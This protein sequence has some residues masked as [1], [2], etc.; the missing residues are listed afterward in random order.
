MSSWTH[1]RKLSGDAT[2]RPAADRPS[3]ALDAAF[4]SLT[5][6][7][8]APILTIA[9]E[10]SSPSLA[11]TSHDPRPM[12]LW[13]QAGLMQETRNSRERTSPCPGCRSSN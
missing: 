4:S 1:V 13:Q 11:I 2:G 7:R 10:T 8:A 5:F 12:S 6:R 9:A 3:S